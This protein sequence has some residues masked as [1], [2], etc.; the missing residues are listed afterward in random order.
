MRAKYCSYP[1]AVSTTFQRYSLNGWNT[2]IENLTIYGG[3]PI[4]AVMKT[5]QALAVRLDKA[6][7]DK[8]RNA[9]TTRK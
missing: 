3:Q 9:Q 1:F 4:D 5:P 8:V 6:L 7:Q 2:L